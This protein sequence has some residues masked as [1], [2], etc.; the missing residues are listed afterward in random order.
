MFRIKPD[1]RNAFP[2]RTKSTSCV[3]TAWSPVLCVNAKR[4]PRCEP[5]QFATPEESTAGYTVQLTVTEGAGLTR[6][7]MSEKVD[8]RLDHSEAETRVI[9]D[10]VEVS[11]TKPATPDVQVTFTPGRMR[12]REGLSPAREMTVANAPAEFRPGLAAMGLPVRRVTRQANGDHNASE[13]IQDAGQLTGESNVCLFLHPPFAVNRDRWSVAREFRSSDNAKTSKG[14]L[15]YRKTATNAQQVTVDVTGTLKTARDVTSE[16]GITVTSASLTFSGTQTF[17]LERMQ[18]V[19][20][21]LNV[22]LTGQARKGSERGRLAANMTLSLQPRDVSDLPS[23]PPQALAGAGEGQ[24]VRPAGAF[25]WLQRRAAFKTELKR[26]GPAPHDFDPATPPPGVREVTYESDDLEL[27]AWYAAPPD[28]GGRRVPALVFFHGGFAFGPG[29][30]EVVRPF[31]DA[32]FAVMTPMLRGENGNAGDF[33]LFGGEFDDARYAIRWVAQ[34]PEVDASRIY[35]FGH[36][37]GGGISALLSLAEEPLPLRHCGSSGGLYPMK[38]FAAWSDFCPFDF[39]DLQECRMRLLLG[40]Q[41]DMQRP[42]FA[43][44]GRQDE[45][46]AVVATAREEAGPSGQL[47]VVLVDGDHFSSLDRSVNAYLQLIQAEL[48]SAATAAT[49]A[50]APVAQASTDS[51]LPEPEF[52]F[53]GTALRH[54]A[55]VLTTAAGDIRH[56]IY[57]P[58]PRQQFALSGTS[59]TFQIWDAKTGQVYRSGRHEA[60]IEC[61]AFCG[62][63]ATF[64]YGTVDGRLRFYSIATRQH[65][66]NVAVPSGNVVHLIG[67]PDDRTYAAATSRGDLLWGTVPSGRNKSAPATIASFGSPVTRLAW[68]DSSGDELLIATADGTLRRF[69]PQKRA[70]SAEWNLDAGRINDFALSLDR[71]KVVVATGRLGAVSVNLTDGALT[72][73][74]FSH[75]EVISVAVNPVSG[76]CAIGTDEDMVVLMK[77]LSAQSISMSYT[78]RAGGAKYLIFSS[79]GKAL[80]AAGPESNQLRVWDLT[81][82]P[83]ESGNTSSNPFSNL[84][85]Q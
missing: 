39:N 55:A 65:T 83:N 57:A 21:S 16:E 73:R 81:R 54:T 82:S 18:W 75:D 47:Q 70:A 85:S 17:S 52:D 20:G 64:A 67:T 34:Q 26:H 29:Q 25:G 12:I 72:E 44:L 35:A 7:H 46:S 32:G 68:L 22:K 62:D 43:W 6:H 66:A 84:F 4:A 15:T 58:E 30:F 36:S 14:T 28:S 56:L 77:G 33:E 3:P 31:L 76:D 1:P 10:F 24:S 37:A 61:V 53:R 9:M 19:S 8:Y 40:N 41:L 60:G 63:N 23:L 13:V 49:V 38:I 59:G 69:D 79:D 45:L 71:Q 5:I 78:S 2:A 42:H 51:V 80:A 50:A 48:P 27:K 11:A 74:L